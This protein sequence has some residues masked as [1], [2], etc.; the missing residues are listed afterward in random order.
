MRNTLSLSCVFLLTFMVIF[1]AIFVFVSGSPSVPHPSPHFPHV[2]LEQSLAPQL[3]MWMWDICRNIC[4]I[5]AAA[6]S[7]DVNIYRSAFHMTDSAERHN[8]N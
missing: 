3:S 4:H 6:M 1:V 8:F 5:Y 7:Q 2:S